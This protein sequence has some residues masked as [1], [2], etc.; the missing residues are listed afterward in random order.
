MFNIL[1]QCIY[2][3]E[4]TYV[5]ISCLV[6][7]Q[8]LIL[9]VI[10]L[11]L[12]M[13]APPIGNIVTQR[14][15]SCATR[16]CW[17]V[18]LLEPC[19]KLNCIWTLLIVLSHLIWTPLKFVPPPEQISWTHSETFVPTVHVDQPQEGRSVHVNSH[20]VTTKDISGVYSDISKTLNDWFPPVRLSWP[21]T[22]FAHNVC[23]NECSM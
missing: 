7:I 20:E 23:G 22:A 11:V 3:H 2:I 14:D 13:I 12:F 18:T 16:S 19:W 6:L 17:T 4:A 9:V 5:E 15:L 8:F 10:S 21:Y 1:L